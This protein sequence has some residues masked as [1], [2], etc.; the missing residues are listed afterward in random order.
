MTIYTENSRVVQNVRQEIQVARD[1]IKKNSEELRQIEL[2]KAE[3]ELTV[4][5]A[6]AESLKRQLSQ[7]EGEISALDG[8]GRELQD[9]KRETA[10][11]EQSYQTYTRKLEESL[12]MDDMERHKMMAISVVE[13]AAAPATLKKQK[14]DKATNGRGRVLRRYCG[15]YR[16]RISP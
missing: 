12:I 16:P 15:R 3:G 13:K 14:L 9:L 7:V 5:R 8:R 6:R 2:G 1:S 4:I 11:Q 10:E